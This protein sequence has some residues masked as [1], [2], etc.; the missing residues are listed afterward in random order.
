MKKAITSL[1]ALMVSLTITLAGSGGWVTGG[2]PPIGVVKG[3]GAQVWHYTASYTDSFFGQVTCTGV[4]QSG[5]NFGTWGQDSFTCT[6][7]PAGAAL[8]NVIPNETLTL[9]IFGGWQSDYGTLIGL[10][11][12]ATAFNGVVSSDGT[13]Y[14]AVAKY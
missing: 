8:Q 4:H 13:S 9:G 14:T 12:L 11:K 2:T 10:G 1:M 7:Q 5:K 3:N 6:A